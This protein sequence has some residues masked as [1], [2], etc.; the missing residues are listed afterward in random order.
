M[1]KKGFTL[2]ELLVAA[3]IISILLV[4]ATVQYRN[5]AAETRWSQAKAR[6]KVLANAVQ[7]ANADYPNIPLAGKMANSYGGSCSLTRLTTGVTPAP[8]ELIDCGYL[9]NG[10]WDDG[11]FEYYACQYASGSSISVCKSNALACVKV[12]SGAKLPSAYA[13]HMY[14]V[15]DDSEAEYQ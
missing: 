5:S 8:H 6:L 4:F 2:I 10:P 9:E 14:C 7:Q 3:T 13:G 15:W 1:S 11:Y 12:A